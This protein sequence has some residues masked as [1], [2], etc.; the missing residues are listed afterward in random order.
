MRIT[1]FAAAFCLT[2]AGTASAQLPGRGALGGSNPL[3]ALGGGNSGAGG[4]LG[5]LP[6]VEQASTGNL[7][8]VLQFC[9]KNNYLGGGSASGVA[10]SLMG[11][12]SQKDSGFQSGSRGM[13]DTGGGQH[14]QLG[15]GS[16]LKEQITRKVCDQVLQR[17]KSLM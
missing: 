11:R 14:Y 13:L 16:S 9:V 1:L 10:Q 15:G 5:G 4:G 8:G 17:G 6:S 3:G 7:A 2:V 12:T